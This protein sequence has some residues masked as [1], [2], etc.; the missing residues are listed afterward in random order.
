MNENE[1]LVILVKLLLAITGSGLFWGLIGG[2]LK[3]FVNTFL[4]KPL[5]KRHHTVER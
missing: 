4:D 5:A 2:A 3:N 1:P